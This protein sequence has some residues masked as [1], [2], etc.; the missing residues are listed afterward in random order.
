LLPIALGDTVEHGL[1]DGKD[2][3]IALRQGHAKT[4]ELERQ[5]IL[6]VISSSA[7]ARVC[8]RF[9]DIVGICSWEVHTLTWKR[10]LLRQC[11]D[12]VASS[13]P[14]AV[15]GIDRWLVLSCA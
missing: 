2:L 5:F 7:A 6:P 4:V 12:C 1:V 11:S 10:W 13:E 8:C 15:W 3:L 14:P 9:R